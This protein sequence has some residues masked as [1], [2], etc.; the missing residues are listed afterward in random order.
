MRIRPYDKL[1][2]QEQRLIEDHINDVGCWRAV[3]PPIG[4]YE[5][6]SVMISFNTSPRDTRFDEAVAHTMHESVAQWCTRNHA[7]V[8][9][10][11]PL[12]LMINGDDGS[13]YACVARISIEALPDF[14]DTLH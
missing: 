4:T 6:Q 10:D 2:P 11:R 1:F 7:T 14:F 9:P 3:W 8:Y 5:G 12:Y 13:T